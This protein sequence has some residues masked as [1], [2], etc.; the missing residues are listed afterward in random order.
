MKNKNN[1]NSNNQKKFQ[2]TAQV[3]D[4]CL[5]SPVFSMI[6]GRGGGRG[7]EGMA[8]ITNDVLKFR[9]SIEFQSS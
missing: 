6:L 5:Q 8:A 1:N 7:G 9:K 3:C 4:V 2:R